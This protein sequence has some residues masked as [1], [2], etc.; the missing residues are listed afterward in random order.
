MDAD[1]VV[2]NYKP[3]I[4]IDPSWEM[5]ELGEICEVG[6]SKRIFKDEY[7]EDG[8]PFFRTKETCQP[9]KKKKGD[10]ISF[11]LFISNSKYQEIKRIP[12]SS[13]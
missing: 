5:V 6:S 3:T 10:T 13:N 1:R 12:C 7:A 8:I 4:D 11:E 9:G 2:E